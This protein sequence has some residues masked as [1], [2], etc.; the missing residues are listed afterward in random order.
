[1]GE[2]HDEVL[3]L[4]GGA[5]GL[6]C[7]LA[8][9]D[10]GR[11]VRVLERDTVGAATSHG[12]CGTITPSHAP[13][14]TEPATLLKAAR[15][16]LQPDAPL[17]LKPR[18]DP[19]LWRW[20]LGFAAHCNHRHAVYA[21]RARGALLMLS[22]QAMADWVQTRSLDCE[23]EAC[24]LTE[25]YRDPRALAADA[26][27]LPLLAE[28]GIE[29]RVMGEAEL[30]AEEP[31]LLPGQAGAI[32]FPGDAH[33]RPDRYC[34]E[35]A[36][37]VRAA[38][39]VIEEGVTVQGFRTEG[40]RIVDVATSDGPR[41]APEV[42]LAL[43]PWSPLIAREL[44]LRLP[45]QPGKGY[46]ITYDR[47][48][49]APRRPL[50]L[51]DRSVCVTAW[52]S[53]YRLGST[54]EFSGYDDALTRVRLDALE[55]GARESL[56]EPLG[57]A[58]REEWFGWRPISVDDLPLLGRSPRHD[59]LWLATGHGM[60]GITLSAAT[61]RLLADLMTGGE[62]PVDPRPFDPARFGALR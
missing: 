39:G 54:M 40:G 48:Q 18:W 8:L 26:A 24:G 60:L 11:A 1:M 27:V 15:W 23:F 22:R 37:C 59:N 38:G 46:S 13:P 62:P 31:A 42:L 51:R 10:A 6:A 33:L 43:G 28:L 32:H 58:K 53:G 44:G 52:G 7:A 57:P 36:R 34:D 14:L 56:I 41:R 45:I 30:L 20:L 35:L 2:A 12:N 50:V 21:T 47:P 5:V 17:Y 3:I 16:L 49:R 29:S 25:V 19:V 9:L 61:G 55:R 4:G